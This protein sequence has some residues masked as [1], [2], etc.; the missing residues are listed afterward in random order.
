LRQGHGKAADWW[1]LGAL[2]YDMTTGAVSL[3]S[4]FSVKYLCSIVV[5]YCCT[6][7]GSRHISTRLSGAHLSTAQLNEC[8]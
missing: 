5:A 3:Y 1:S 6:C 2:L 8:D 4:L 7:V